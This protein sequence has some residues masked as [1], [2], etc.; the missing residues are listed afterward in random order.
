MI[1]REM[2]KLKFKLNLQLFGGGIFAEGNEPTT[3][4][5]LLSDSDDTDDSTSYDDFDDDDNTSEEVVET[6][7]DTVVVDT[8]TKVDV[9]EPIAKP[10]QPSYEEIKSQLDTILNRMNAKDEIK[11]EVKVEA[12]KELTPE[13]IEQRNND[14]YL[15]FT[16][17]PLEALQELIEQRANEKMAPLQEYFDNIQKV[18]YWNKELD[19]FEKAHPDFKEYVDDVSKIIASDESIRGSKNPIELAYKVAKADK[20]DIINRPLHEQIKD[21]GNLKKLLEDPEIKNMLINELKLGKQVT[22]KVIG[23][24]GRTSINVED[25]PKTMSEATKAWLNS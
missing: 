19:T 25:K 24:N 7:A 23:T 2:Q 3:T 9:V 1:R 6:N 15:K 22:P 16:E 4:N 13:E 18:D 10:T 5:P 11:P 21:A 17:K 20:M 8:P 14:F 12:P